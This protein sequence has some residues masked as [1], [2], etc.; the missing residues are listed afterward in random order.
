MKMFVH[1]LGLSFAGFEQPLVTNYLVT[2]NTLTFCSSE[3]N[4]GVKGA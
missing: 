2:L 4:F 1:S 3:M